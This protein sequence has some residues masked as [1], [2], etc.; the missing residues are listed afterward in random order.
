MTNDGGISYWAMISYDYYNALVLTMEEVFNKKGLRLLSNYTPH[1]HTIIDQ[2]LMLQQN[3]KRIGSNF[4]KNS[5]ILY[6]GQLK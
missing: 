4:I 5:L 2:N 3:L 1:Y 6:I